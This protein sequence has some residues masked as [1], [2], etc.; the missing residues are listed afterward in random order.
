M[1]DRGFP[2][3]VEGSYTGNI[4]VRNVNNWVLVLNIFHFHPYLGEWSNLTNVFKWFETTN[5][6]SLKMFF[7]QWY[8]FSMAYHDPFLLGLAVYWSLKI[9]VSPH[10]RHP[11][12]SSEIV[13][14]FTSVVG[15]ARRKKRVGP[16]KNGSCCCF[17]FQEMHG[18]SSH[19]WKLL[20]KWIFVNHLP[21]FVCILENW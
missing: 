17:F 19:V 9:W 13:G 16:P 20:C 6:T 14:G 18:C 8:G 11:S 10:S 12:G 4:P 5:W 15:R 21:S 1:L 7:L 2:R 3:C